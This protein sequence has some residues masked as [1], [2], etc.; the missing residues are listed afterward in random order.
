MSRYGCLVVLLGLA[1][2]SGRAVS[3]YPDGY[4]DRQDAGA[5]EGGSGD[6][7]AG[8]ASDGPMLFPDGA[9]G[10]F[11]G[12][13]ACNGL[14]ACETCPDDCGICTPCGDGACDAAASEDCASCAP[15][16]GLCPTCPN[17]AC[18][19]GE[20]CESCS[21]DCGLC[22]LCGDGYCT[23]S[24]DCIS[25]TPDCGGCPGCGDGGCNGA[26]ENCTLCPDDCGE[27]ASCG[28][29]G[30]GSD[31]TCFSCNLDC[32]V[33]AVCGNGSC[34]DDEF[35]TC[36]N[37]PSDCGVCPVYDCLEMMMCVFGCGFDQIDLSCFNLCMAQGCAD[38]QSAANNFLECAIDSVFSGQCDG[39]GGPGG[40]DFGCIQKACQAE[41]TTCLAGF[42]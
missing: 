3:Y 12:D 16:C 42:C 8:P 19:A 37:C 13:G 21:L 5:A 2:C 27:C 32:G 14:E 22:E 9:M 15:D 4:Y 24:E 26:T 28:M 20:D 10:D 31:E 7:D 18:D 25:C 39:G 41:F 38:A 17:G 6:R 1:A 23:A 40:G 29:G 30:C 11:C 34:E 36:V 33:C 35:E